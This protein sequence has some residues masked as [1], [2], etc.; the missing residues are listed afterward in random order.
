MVDGLKYAGV[1]ERAVSREGHDWPP[2]EVRWLV[3]EMC[4]ELESVL[5]E[6]ACRALIEFVRRLAQQ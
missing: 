2:N 3:S 4:V 1:G 5:T 6:N